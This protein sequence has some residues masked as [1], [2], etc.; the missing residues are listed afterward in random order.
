MACSRDHCCHGNATI[1]SLSDLHVAVNNTTVE[2]C[3][4]NATIRS[5]RIAAYLRVAGNK[6]KLL[7]VAMET[8]QYVPFVS[9]LTTC[10]CQQYKTVEYC[11][12][13][14]TIRSLC[15]AADVH[16]AGNNIKRLNVAKETQQRV[17]FVSL[18]TQT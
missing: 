3:H 6:I 15:I 8:Q 18:L 17:P 13:N 10:S 5:L 2:C 16:V 7:N 4:R 11:H 9:L 14:A 12:R 1:R